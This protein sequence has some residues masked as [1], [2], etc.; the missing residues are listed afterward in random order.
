MAARWS[1]RENEIILKRYPEEGGKAL[2][3]SLPGRTLAAIHLQAR[4]LGVHCKNEA[5]RRGLRNSHK[6]YAI[7]V[8]VPDELLECLDAI[9][10]DESRAAFVRNLIAQAVGRPD[11]AEEK[12]R[13]RGKRR[14]T[15]RE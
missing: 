9:V 2:Q 8:P 12:P 10:G 3:E 14:L 15:D 5:L 6:P 7:T 11:L 4:F 1:D 13:K